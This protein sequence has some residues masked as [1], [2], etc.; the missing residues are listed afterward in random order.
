MK[1][2]AK[3]FDQWLSEQSKHNSEIIAVSRG[4]F[5]DCENLFLSLQDNLDQE[6][7][8]FYDNILKI[9]RDRRVLITAINRA[10]NDYWRDREIG[11]VEDK[12]YANMKTLLNLSEQNK[13]MSEECIER[14]TRFKNTLDLKNIFLGHDLELFK[15][16]FF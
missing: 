13:A 8:I 7:R 1:S 2:T 4:L 14:L 10:T 5:Y 11:V 9:Q 16:S 6:N 3:D 12:I 15:F